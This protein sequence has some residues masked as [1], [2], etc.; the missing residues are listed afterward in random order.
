MV[1]IFLN[2][3][4]INPISGEEFDLSLNLDFIPEDIEA[5][6]NY[7]KIPDGARKSALNKII[8]LGLKMGY[9]Q[10]KS[11]VIERTIERA[12]SKLEEKSRD[13]ISAEEASEIAS[14]IT[15]E[16]MPFILHNMTQHDEK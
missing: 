14:L 13:G 10:E 8:P 1:R 6:Y 5:S 16:L 15:S 7:E 4:S 9:E 12:L 11:R 2:S 3:Y